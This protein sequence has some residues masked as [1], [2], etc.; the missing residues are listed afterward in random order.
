M[1]VFSMIELTTLLKLL[2]LSLGGAVFFLWERQNYKREIRTGLATA[3]GLLTIICGNEWGL[4]GLLTPILASGIGFSLYWISAEGITWGQEA[5]FER[6]GLTAD[7]YMKM[8]PASQYVMAWG[9]NKTTNT[10][11]KT[12]LGETY[13]KQRGGYVFPP[14]LIESIMHQ[15]MQAGLTV[16][17][18]PNLEGLVPDDTPGCEAAPYP[19]PPVKQR[20]PKKPKVGFYQPTKS[21]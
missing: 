12:Q 3:T 16:A 17:T 6:R 21:V 9:L 10:F 7:I 4:F 5:A 13:P 15:F 1:E 20:E 2:C 14:N 11:L 19:M 18:H 8:H